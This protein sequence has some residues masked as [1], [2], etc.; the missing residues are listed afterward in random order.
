MD[1]NAYVRKT[2]SKAI[3]ECETRC[4]NGLNDE[5]QNLLMVQVLGLKSIKMI[6]TK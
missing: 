5:D 3:K 2:N 4:T 1:N 6:L